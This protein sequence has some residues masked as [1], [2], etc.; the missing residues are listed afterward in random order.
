VSAGDCYD[1]TPDELA[2][3]ASGEGGAAVIPIR[4]GLDTTRPIIHVS[5]SLDTQGDAAVRALAAEGNLFAQAGHL[6][7]IVRI[8]PP[9]ATASKPSGTPE[10]RRLETETVRELMAKH[11]VWLREGKQGPAACHPPRD[12]ASAVRKRGEWPGIRPLLAV[13]EAPA[14]RPDGSVFAEPGYDE[15]MRCVLLPDCQTP[16][17]RGEPTQAQAMKALAALAEPFLEFPW[18]KPADLYVC[19]AAILTLYARH[20]IQGA[21]PAILLDSSVAGSGKTLASGVIHAAYT[22]RWAEPNTLPDDDVELEKSLAGE[23]LAAS[24][25]VDFDNAE[26]LLESAP[27]LKVLTVRDRVRLRVLGTNQ[28]VSLPWRALVIVGGNNLVIGRQMSRRCLVARMEPREERPELRAGFKLDLPRWTTANRA[29]LSAAAL[30]VLRAYVCAGRPPCDVPLLGSYEEWSALIPRAIVH[31]GGLDVTSCRP[32]AG[33]DGDDPDTAALRLLLPAWQR[34]AGGGMTAADALRVLYPGGKA[35]GRDHPPD[36]YDGLREAIE[37][38]GGS[39]RGSP[40]GLPPSA[41]DLGYRLRRLKGRWLAGKRLI[42]VEIS[43]V[44]AWSVEAA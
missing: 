18:A 36:G 33:A 28:K 13:L 38:L 21:I 12:V 39:R 22:G 42:S 31:A 43:G 6:V 2:E 30:T 34:L 20:A 35:P 19:V 11:A 29:R 8:D 5:D 41:R 44:Q 3:I 1:P 10:L 40:P 7:R 27:L 23:A 32:A 26:G 24:P 37:S 25:I 4:P 16:T 17:V 15:D 9:S 14:L